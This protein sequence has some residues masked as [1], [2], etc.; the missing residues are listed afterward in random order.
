MI[1]ALQVAL[2]FVLVFVGNMYDLQALS[3]RKDPSRRLRQWDSWQPE[4]FDAEGNRLRRIARRFYL[5]AG[6]VFLIPILANAFW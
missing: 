3:H 5:L 4:L 6:A 2:L 1:A